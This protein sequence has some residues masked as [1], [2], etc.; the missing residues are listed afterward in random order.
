MNLRN[1]QCWEVLILL[2]FFPFP[3]WGLIDNFQFRFPLVYFSQFAPFLFKELSRVNILLVDL[4]VV[5]NNC[6]SSQVSWAF[7]TVQAYRKNAVVWIIP[8]RPPSNNSS[9]SIFKQL[10]TVQSAPI[11]IVIPITF[12]FNRFL[13][14][15]A[16]FQYLSLFRFLLYSICGL[17]GP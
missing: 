6:K 10:S 15:L 16:K 3:V 11:A 12:M 7:L 13:T 17:L 9:G 2:L 1:L 5:S 14:S 4:S 8:V